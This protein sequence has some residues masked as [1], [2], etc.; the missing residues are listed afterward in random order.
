MSG[1]GWAS[2]HGR[3]GAAIGRKWQRAIDK[4]SAK[5]L[6]PAAMVKSG[7]GPKAVGR[8][9]APTGWA[10]AP[11]GLANRAQ[12]SATDRTERGEKV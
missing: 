5:Q 11:K 9:G 6:P 7:R 1:G 12:V 3:A 10:P 2:I 4:R 8:A